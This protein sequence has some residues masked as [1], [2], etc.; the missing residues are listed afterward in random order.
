VLVLLPPVPVVE[1]LELFF[2]FFDVLLELVSPEVV[3]VE[4]E[5]LAAVLFL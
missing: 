3:S 1:V 4:F 2:D 5:L